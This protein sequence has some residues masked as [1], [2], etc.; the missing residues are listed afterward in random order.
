M[1][2]NT[3]FAGHLAADPE[4]GMSPNGIPYTRF[5]VISNDRYTDRNGEWVSGPAVAT[6]VSTF[7][8]LAV[9]IADCLHT[10]SPVVVS[11]TL[12]T[13]FYRDK[14][15]G[16]QRPSRDLTADYVAANLANATVTITKNTRTATDGQGQDPYPEEPA[17]PWDNGR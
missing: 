16:E 15:T 1:S 13:K 12:T 17:D 2:A 9:N 11:G 3:T 7:R 14:N 5:V 8:Q 10:G 6:R 4:H